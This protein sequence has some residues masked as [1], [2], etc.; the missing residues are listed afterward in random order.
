VKV[1]G[2]DTVGALRTTN[3]HEK[4]EINHITQGEPFLLI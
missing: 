2:A 1:K 4:K 3:R